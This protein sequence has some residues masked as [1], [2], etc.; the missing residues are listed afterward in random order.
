MIA[1]KKSI[2][3]ENP[4]VDPFLARGT[5]NFIVSNVVAIST[6]YKYHA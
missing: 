2:K 6:Y 1:D 3:L 4:R 5:V